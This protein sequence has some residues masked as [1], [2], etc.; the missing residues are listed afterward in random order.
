M[1]QLKLEELNNL[2][3]NS[4]AG[5]GRDKTDKARVLKQDGYLKGSIVIVLTFLLGIAIAVL[6]LMNR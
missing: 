5:S 4:L 1:L 6:L 2:F 3:K